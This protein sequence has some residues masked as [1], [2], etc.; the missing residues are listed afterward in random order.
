MEIISTL[1][2]IVILSLRCASE[3]AEGENHVSFLAMESIGKD[4]WDQP[5]KG[6]GVRMSV[7]EESECAIKRTMY[8][9]LGWEVWRMRFP[10]DSSVTCKHKFP[11]LLPIADWRQLSEWKHYFVSI[12]NVPVSSYLCVADSTSNCVCIIYPVV[13]SKLMCIDQYDCVWKEVAD[14]NWLIFNLCVLVKKHYPFN[15]WIYIGV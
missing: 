6:E 14:R 10:G 4:W 1:S 8:S 2:F 11:L 12:I 13:Q 5:D 3:T 9:S 7:R 15:A